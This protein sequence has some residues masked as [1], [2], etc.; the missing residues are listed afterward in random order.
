MATNIDTPQSL[1]LGTPTQSPS[2]GGSAGAV[3][4]PPADYPLIQVASDLGTV[5]ASWD[6][7]FNEGLVQSTSQV[8]SA[9]PGGSAPWETP[10][11]DAIAK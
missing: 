6:S 5:A 9:D 2:G 3:P 11:K 7:P 10:F 4:G 1:N 8:N